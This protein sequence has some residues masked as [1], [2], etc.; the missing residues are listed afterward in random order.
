MSHAVT[1]AAFEAP[2]ITPTKRSGQRLERGPPPSRH[3]YEELL[4]ALR[5]VCSPP[6]I[7]GAPC[8]ACYFQLPFL[9]LMMCPYPF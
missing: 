5:K 8:W 7:P 3:S 9:R 2:V 4:V 1:A 6:Q